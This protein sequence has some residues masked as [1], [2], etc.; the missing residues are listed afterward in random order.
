MVNQALAANSAGLI[1]NG[2]NPELIDL[3]AATNL[4]VVVLD[5]W[6]KETSGCAEGS[7]ETP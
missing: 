7:M 3:A 2:D 4:P 6:E 1:V 5:T